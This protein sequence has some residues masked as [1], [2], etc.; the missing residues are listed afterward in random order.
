[1][2]FL[3]YPQAQGGVILNGYILG[4][5]VGGTVPEGVLE[6]MAALGG[7]AANSRPD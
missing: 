7:A 2:S 5:A 6:R 3:R 4:G 1:M